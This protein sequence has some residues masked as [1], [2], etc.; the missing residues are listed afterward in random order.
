MVKRWRHHFPNCSQ[1]PEFEHVQDFMPILVTCKFDEETI[2]NEYASVETFSPLALE[3]YG[4]KFQC[5]RAKR[6]TVNSLIWPEFELVRDFM[7]VLVICKFDDNRIKSEGA[8]V[9]IV[10]PIISQW[11]LSVAMETSF[12]WICHKC[13]CSHSPT[14]VMLHMK[15]DRDWLT[16]LR[17]I[18]V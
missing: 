8:R 15:F 16:G 7:P 6:S 13:L 18:Q 1:W 2:N 11:E 5:S 17:D 12:N 10:F 9:D 14:P 3:V 4:K